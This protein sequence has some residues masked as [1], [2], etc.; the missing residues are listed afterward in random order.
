FQEDAGVCRRGK[1]GI[2]RRLRRKGGF[3]RLSFP[4]RSRPTWR[5]SR[6]FPDRRFRTSE[7]EED[8]E[9]LPS[10][11]SLDS[12]PGARRI[13]RASRGRPTEPART[14]PRKEESPLPGRVRT[15]LSRL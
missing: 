4:L 14:R 10:R 9:E 2:R 3:Q 1:E 13:H 7:E 15:I 12:K 8:R 6:C 11:N 5:R